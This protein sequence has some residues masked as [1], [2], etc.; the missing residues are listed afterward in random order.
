MSDQRAHGF[1]ATSHRSPMQGGHAVV[2]ACVRIEAAGQHRLQDAS[3][4]ALGRHLHHEMV[5]GCS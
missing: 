5:F 1:G 4:A 3:V 2:I